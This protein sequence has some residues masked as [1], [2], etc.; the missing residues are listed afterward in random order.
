MAYRQGSLVLTPP[1]M[2]LFIVAVV[3]AVAAALAHYGNIAIPVVSEHVIDTL[4]VAFLIL[5]AGVLMRR[6]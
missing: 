1:S 4:V 3:L 6:V 2:P 5:T